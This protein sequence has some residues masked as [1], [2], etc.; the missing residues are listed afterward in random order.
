MRFSCGRVAFF[1]IF[2][3]CKIRARFGGVLGGSG[4]GFLRHFGP[5]LVDFEGSE[6]SQISSSK[7]EGEKVVSKSQEGIRGRVQAAQLLIVDQS[8]IGI[9]DH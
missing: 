3:V 9:I 6:R 8:I 1:L 5:D 2:G 4:G 7:L